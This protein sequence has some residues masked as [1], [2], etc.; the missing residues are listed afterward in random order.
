MT[1]PKPADAERAGRLSYS[2]QGAA[3]AIGVSARTIQRKI[4]DG[5]LETFAIGRRTLIPAES[6]RQMVSRYR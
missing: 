2:I 6:L 4:A 1:A 5:E 3:E